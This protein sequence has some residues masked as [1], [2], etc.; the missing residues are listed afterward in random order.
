MDYD[1][2][3]TGDGVEVRMLKSPDYRTRSECGRDCNPEPSPD[4]GLGVRVLFVCPEHGAQSIV[5][6]FQDRR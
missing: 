3:E 2:F 6:P 1:K 5:D 4:D